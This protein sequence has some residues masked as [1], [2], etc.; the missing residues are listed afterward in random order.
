MQ[1]RPLLS[2]RQGDAGAQTANAGA[3]A[4]ALPLNGRATGKPKSSSCGRLPCRANAAD[5]ARDAPRRKV[6]RTAPRRGPG[7]ERKVVRLPAKCNAVCASHVFRGPSWLNAER[8]RET[9]TTHPYGQLLESPGALSIKRGQFRLRSTSRR[10]GSRFCSGRL[11][12]AGPRSRHSTRETWT[13]DVHRLW[14]T[15]T[16]M[17]GSHE[18]KR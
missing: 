14:K 6:R 7:R 16:A 18:W 10:L 12:R 4:A 3:S 9:A 2:L 17:R 13:R 15:G 8:D 1:G 5:T 11:L